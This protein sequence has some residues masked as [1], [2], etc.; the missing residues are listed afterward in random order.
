MKFKGRNG[1]MAMALR[2]HIMLF[3][4]FVISL[5]IFMIPTIIFVCIKNPYFWIFLIAPI[6][7]LVFSLVVFLFIQYDENVFLEGNPKDHL[8]EIKNNCLFKDGKEIKL[9][10][11]VK[12]YRYKGFL[13]METSHSMFVIKDTDFLIVDRNSFLDWTKLSHIRIL[14]GY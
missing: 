12:I 2:N 4:V 5:F 10:Q 9:I 1:G 7:F 8:F 14:R 6:M 13:Y 3:R 11:S